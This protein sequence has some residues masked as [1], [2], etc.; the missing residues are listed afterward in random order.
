MSFLHHINTFYSIYLGFEPAFLSNF[1][2]NILMFAEHFLTAW[3]VTPMQC[4]FSNQG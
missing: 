2:F 3:L 1:L 4:E